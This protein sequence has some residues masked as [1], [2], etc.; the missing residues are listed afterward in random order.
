MDLCMFVTN[1]NDVLKM[2]DSLVME[3]FL[4]AKDNCM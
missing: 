4:F 3:D 1:N 2:K